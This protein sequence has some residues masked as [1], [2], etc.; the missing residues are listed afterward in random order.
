VADAAAQWNEMAAPWRAVAERLG[1]R[2]L[3][4]KV[5]KTQDGHTCTDYL[6]DGA[7]YLDLAGSLGE[8]HG[9]WSATLTT[10]IDGPEGRFSLTTIGVPVPRPRPRGLLGWLLGAV[11]SP[12][13]QNLAPDSDRPVPMRSPADLEIVVKKHAG[14]LLAIGGKP[15]IGARR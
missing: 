9:L 13:L 15:L 8:V 11:A 12:L 2:L 4:R 3:D 5:Y 10:W 1:F 14:E 6:V 7:T